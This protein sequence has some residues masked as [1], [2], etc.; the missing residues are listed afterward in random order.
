MTQKHRRLTIER[1][2]V[3]IIRE[4]RPRTQADCP[5]CGRDAHDLPELAPAP[6]ET[7]DTIMRTINSSSG[8]KQ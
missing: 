5:H 6:S 1:Y 4:N 7:I 8:E 2:K 3:S